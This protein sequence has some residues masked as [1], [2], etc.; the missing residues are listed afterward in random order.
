MGVYPCRNVPACLILPQLDV[1]NTDNHFSVDLVERAPSSPLLLNACLAVAARHL[2]HT[3]NTVSPDAADGH[4][5]RCI[6]YLLPVLENGAADISI[7]TLLAATVTLR[8]FEQI[9]CT[10]RTQR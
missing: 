9:S 6:V 8:L 3:A 1:Y 10:S 4:H 5:E 2:S 7:D